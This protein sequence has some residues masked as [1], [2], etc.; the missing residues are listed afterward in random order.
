MKLTAAIAL[1]ALVAGCENAYAAGSYGYAKSYESTVTLVGGHGVLTAKN[2]MT[3]YTFAKDTK[4]K[5]NCSGGCADSW[6]PYLAKSGEKAP[7]KGFSKIKRADGSSQWAKNG[8]AL[9]F[10]V[11]DSAPG[12]TTGDGVGGVWNVAK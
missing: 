5:S 1:I 8:E 4:G 10:W 3:L 9:Y 7:G 6:P 12:D 2:G 11:G